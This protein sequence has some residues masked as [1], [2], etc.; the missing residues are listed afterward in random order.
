MTAGVDAEVL[1]GVGQLV[2]DGVG[3][4]AGRRVLADVP[5]RRRPARGAGAS[6]VSRPSTVTGPSRVPPV[7]WGTSP[8][9]APQQGRLAGAGRSDDET[10]LALGDPQVDVAQDRS[11]RRRDR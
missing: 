5:R 4:E 7:K 2:L 10:Q 1:H 11:C 9:I 8:L 3:D 6:A